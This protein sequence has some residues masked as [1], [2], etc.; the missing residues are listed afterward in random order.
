MTSLTTNLRPPT[1]NFFWVQTTRFAESFE[2]LTGF[3]AITDWRKS[4]PKPRAIQPFL[5]K[6]FTTEKPFFLLL[7]PQV[8][9]VYVLFKWSL[10]NKTTRLF[11][12]LLYVE[13]WK[14]TNYTFEN[15]C[16]PNVAKKQMC[17]RDQHINFIEI[18]HNSVPAPNTRIS[19]AH[20]ISINEIIWH[21]ACTKHPPNIFFQKK[22]YIPQ[23]LRSSHR[24]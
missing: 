18:L 9:C 11:L 14:V 7:V 3:V 22:Q 8:I 23:L 17:L 10:L 13:R 12:T 6:G 15:F 24:Q 5:C 16:I 19:C 1:K 21:I 2:L 4:H 20:I